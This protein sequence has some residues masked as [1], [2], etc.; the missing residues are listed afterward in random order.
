[1]EQHIIE[2]LVMDQALNTLSPDTEQLL[3]A[4]LS[5]HP[6]FQ[7]IADSIHQT[8][9]LGQ[10]AVTVERPTRIPPFPR[11]RLI[12]RLRHTRWTAIQGWK[13]IAAAILIGIS[14]GFVLKQPRHID[15]QPNQLASVVQGPSETVPLSSG[16]DTARA[17]WSSKTYRD[18]YK[19]YLTGTKS[20][21]DRSGYEKYEK[22]GRS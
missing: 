21:A 9:T 22:A 5:E 17:L 6:E 11:E 8:A 16:L 15:H 13:T 14:I 19:N 20:E 18:G 4:Y 1:M 3:K 7:E 2:S 10:N 12:R